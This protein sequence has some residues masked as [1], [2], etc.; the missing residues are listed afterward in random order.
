MQVKVRSV[1]ETPTLL[2]VEGQ[3]PNGRILRNYF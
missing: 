2:E 1:G 3:F